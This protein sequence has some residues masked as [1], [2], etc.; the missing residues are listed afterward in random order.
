MSKYLE[1][2]AEL[3]IGGAHPG[4][5]LLSKKALQS[6]GIS[7]TT[8]ILD[9][10]CGTGQTMEFVN[11][12]YQC[13]VV[14]ID[15][16]PIMVQKANQRFQKLGLSLICLQGYAESLPFEDHSFD[17]VLSESVLVFTD[18][19]LAI[20]EI[21]RVLKPNGKLIAIEMILENPLTYEEKK[22][23]KNFYGF[24][25]FLTED[26]WIEKFT[27]F[28]FEKIIFKK[29]ALGE[30]EEVNH[31]GAPEIKMLDNLDDEQFNTVMQHQ[32]FLMKYADTLGFRM[33]ICG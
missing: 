16:H 30:G 5:L 21:K 1:F 26:A 2:L 25:H 33:I 27:Q 18:I 10:G 24:T 15:S 32:M 31:N 22:E 29:I 11:K 4:G 7:K 23:L 9:V 8:R 13:H 17:Y 3:E 12:H 14:G 20:Q 6:L 28:G 19:P